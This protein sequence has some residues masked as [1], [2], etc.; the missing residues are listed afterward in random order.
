MT[1]RE[2]TVDAR[3]ESASVGAVDRSATSPDAAST[4]A[5]D[6]SAGP[7]DAEPECADTAPAEVVPAPA[8]APPTSGLSLTLRCANPRVRVGESIDLA[9]VVTNHGATDVVVDSGSV[10][11]YPTFRTT[12]GTK[13]VEWPFMDILATGPGR[14]AYWTVEARGS[15]T[16]SRKV[17][18]E[19]GSWSGFGVPDGGPYEGLALVV[20][21]NSGSAIFAIPSLPMTIDVTENWLADAGTV[22]RRARQFGMHGV[23]SGELES[24]PVR[25]ELVEE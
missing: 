17:S 25:V 19:R 14:E 24:N 21:T 1:A 18:L 8:A 23:F 3:P 5:T 9:I 6:V 16:L 22:R 10:I 11:P 20:N 12:D 2:P 4:A 15:S 7:P 13:L